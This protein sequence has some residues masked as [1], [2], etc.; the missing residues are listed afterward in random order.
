VVTV[1]STSIPCLCKTNVQSSKSALGMFRHMQLTLDL[2]VRGQLKWGPQQCGEEDM[3][4]S[5]PSPPKVPAAVQGNNALK[6]LMEMREATTPGPV[7]TV[8]RPLLTH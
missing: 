7:A 6:S 2:Q 1:G 5:H 4:P 8:P 3:K